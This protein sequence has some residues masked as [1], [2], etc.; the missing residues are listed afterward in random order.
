MRP[1][2]ALLACA[3]FT[4]LSALA[5]EP[6][7]ARKVDVVD[8]EF[9]LSIPDPYR[10]MEGENNTEFGAWLKA[11]GAASRAKLDALPALE[12]WRKTLAA[13]AGAA[14]LHGNHTLVGDR[15]FFM[16]S[17]AGKEAMM[18]VRQ[19]DGSEHVLFDPNAV[20]GGASVGG[21]SV[22][23]DGGTVALD[24]TYGGNEIG[25]IA[26]FDAASG[27]RLK[28]TLKPVWDE[29]T[30][31]WLP[32]GSGFFY[33][34][35]R[36][37]QQGDADRMKG[38]GAY[39]HTLGQPQSADRLLARAGTDDA[40]KIADQDFPIVVTTPGSTWA[41]LVIGGARASSPMCVAPLS[42]AKA[43]HAPWRCLIDIS[44]NVQGAVLHG[45]TM[46]LL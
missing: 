30:A 19:A 4:S 13:A 24:V 31:N 20:Q 25:E 28:D 7:V 9:G 21:Y 41:I 27:K 44:D 45:D 35:M 3:F 36:D 43:A 39:L 23:P 40:L 1:V 18:M 33:V 16:R 46:Y 14:T 22:S 15:L 8:H 17:L 11:H 6:P 37:L 12:G 5:A 38:M 42:E 29:F 2:H 10:W 34:R 26:L 32:D